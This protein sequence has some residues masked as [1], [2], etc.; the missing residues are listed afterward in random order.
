MYG[1]DSHGPH[2]LRRSMQYDRSGAHAQHRVWESPSAGATSPHKSH[3]RL[4]I[5]VAFV[6]KSVFYYRLA[7]LAG[8]VDQCST[9]ILLPAV[10]NTSIKLGTTKAN[11]ACRRTY[12]VGVINRHPRRMQLLHFVQLTRLGGHQ[13][14]IAV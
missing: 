3:L 8:S 11:Y 7:A 14:S 13:Q 1:R 9:T 2:A 6:F 4:S 12:L 10:T 5:D